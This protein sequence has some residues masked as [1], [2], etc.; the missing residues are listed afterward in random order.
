[1][2]LVASDDKLRN[3]SWKVFFK[4]W[5]LVL[6]AFFQNFQDQE[7][8]EEAETVHRQALQAGKQRPSGELVWYVYEFMALFH[9][10]PKTQR[11]THGRRA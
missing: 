4:G 1:M 5:I 10:T 6:R 8:M 2:I 9:R 3:I 11:N 7:K